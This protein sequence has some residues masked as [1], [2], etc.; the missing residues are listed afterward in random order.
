MEP[1]AHDERSEEYGPAVVLRIRG[2]HQKMQFEE[3]SIISLLC[4]GQLKLF[5]RNIRS[6]FSSSS[7]SYLSG[8]S[9]RISISAPQLAHSTIWPISLLGGIE[10]AT[11]Q[12]G[13]RVPDWTA[14]AV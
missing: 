11:L 14:I 5:F 10:R 12:S 1:S 13:H 6:Y 3:W 4:E 2:K 8:S 7:I 9:E